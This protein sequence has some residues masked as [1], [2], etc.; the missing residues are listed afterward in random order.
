MILNASNIHVGPWM[1]SMSQRVIN[2]ARWV[3][4]IVFDTCWL[5]Y[6]KNKLSPPPPPK[7][8]KKFRIT[9]RVANSQYPD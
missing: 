8:K 1:I 4:S 6:L 3:I 7:K 2:S 9:V 5:F